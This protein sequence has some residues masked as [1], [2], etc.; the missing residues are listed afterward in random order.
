VPRLLTSELKEL[1]YDSKC[2]QMRARTEDLRSK[3]SACH[4]T[5]TSAYRGPRSFIVDI[6]SRKFKV[7][8]FCFV[9]Y[10]TGFAV[11]VSETFSKKCVIFCQPRFLSWRNLVILY[12]HPDA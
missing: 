11:G 2:T 12:E 9:V 4:P 8:L 1:H 5:N 3:S 10:S 7:G 6:F